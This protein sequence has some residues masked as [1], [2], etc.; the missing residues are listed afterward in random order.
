MSDTPEATRP[1]LDE[2]MLAMDVVDT[3]RHRERVVERALTA[4]DRDRELVGRLQEIYASQGI[5][6]SKAIIERGVEDLRADRF[7]YTPTP[8]SFGRTLAKLYVSRGSW[9]KPLG[10]FVTLA[11]LALVGYQVIVRGPEQEAIAALP[12]ELQTAFAAVVDLAEAPAIDAEAGALLTDGELALARQDYADSRKAIAALDA[13]HSQLAAEYAVR[14]RSTP[15]ELSGVWRIPG[16]NPNAQNFYLIVEAIDAD[17]KRLSLPVT[18]EENG[19]TSTVRRWGQRVDEMTFRA[20]AADKSDDGIIQNAQLGAKRR[21]V[22]EPEYRDGVLA[23]AI[24]D[25]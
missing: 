11:A 16:D 7:V 25:W 15:G 1:P 3:L 19:R 20:V 14:V 24:T 22:L 5:D 18:S 13:L 17:G 9:G 8:P 23:G 21:G 4:D 12:V 2:V 6:V 10:L